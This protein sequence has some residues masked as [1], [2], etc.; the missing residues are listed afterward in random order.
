[1]RTLLIAIV[2]FALWF[3]VGGGIWVNF[4]L[5]TAYDYMLKNMSD[6]AKLPQ[7]ASAKIKS[8]FEEKKGKMIKE[9]EKKKDEYISQIK[10]SIKEQLQKQIENLFK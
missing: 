7:N 2:M 8:I 3:I 10:E 9:L 5:N 4:S 1:M 6:T